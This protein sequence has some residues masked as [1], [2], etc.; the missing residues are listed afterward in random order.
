M[1]RIGT[2]S[3]RCVEEN[4]D[5]RDKPGH[6][7]LMADK[8][9]ANCIALIPGAARGIAVAAL[10]VIVAG[11]SSDADAQRSLRGAWGV[12]WTTSPSVTVLVQGDDARVALVRQAVAFW[13]KTFAELGSPFRLGAV[14]TAKGAISAAELADAS[15][16]VLRHNW[17]AKLPIRGRPL[18]RQ[19]RRRAVARLVRVVCRPLA[20]TKSGA[21]RD[22]QHACLSAHAAQC[23]PQRHRPRA[24]PRHRARH[25]SDPSRLMCGRPAPCR[26]KLF[27]SK[28]ARYFPLTPDEKAELKRMYPADWKSR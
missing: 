12:P 19:Y 13:N 6:D 22:P 16:K 26:P 18:A 3:K 15:T 7:E 2:F 24:R 20:E 25:N 10:L 17:S 21:G 11:F 14:T 28:S 8:P 1:S 9:L 4:V 23:R 5:G 27:A